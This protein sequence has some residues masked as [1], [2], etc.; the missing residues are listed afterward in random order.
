MENNKL[1]KVRIKNRTRYYLD[2]IIKLDDF[3]I[4]NIL[5][6]AKSHKNIL[7]YDISYK[8]LIGSTP[9]RTRFDIKID[10]ITRI[11]D[12]TRY[13]TLFG[14][15]K[16]D[17]FKDKI[18][19]LITIK[20]YMTYTIFHYFAKIKVDSYDSLPIEKYIYFA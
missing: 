11:Y 1:K 8:T 4:D 6:D 13:L 20:S 16:Y 10:G 15:I 18:R 5:I 14:S 3:D 9:L 19:Y 2:D 12:R 7:I 17:A